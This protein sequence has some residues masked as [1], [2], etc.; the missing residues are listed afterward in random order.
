MAW[1]LCGILSATSVGIKVEANIFVSFKSIFS[2]RLPRISRPTTT[3]SDALSK[4]LIGLGNCH[5]LEAEKPIEKPQSHLR[6][7]Q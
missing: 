1:I 3:N 7:G 6:E 5:Q 2:H 4:A